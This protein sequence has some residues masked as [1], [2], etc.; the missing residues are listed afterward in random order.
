MF[1]FGDLIRLL[2]AIFFILPMVTVIRETGYYVVATL[3]GATEKK[4]IIGS[5]PT[6]LKLK[7][8]EIR[9]YFF[10]YSWVEYDEVRPESRFWT[11]L[12][13][14]S[15]ILSNMIVGLTV[16]F[17][18][19]Q[20]ILASNIFWQTFLFY[21]F[22]FVLFDMLPVYLPD[23]QPTNGRAI[24]DLLWHQQQSSYVKSYQDGESEEQEDADTQAQKE[25][26]ENRGRNRE[27]REEE[28]RAGG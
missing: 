2:L 13:Y 25:T 16:N 5:G 7:T 8:I 14:A 27:D 24:F 10:M 17:L 3:L 20:G 9:R 11:L 15:P 1:G 23:G 22:Y 6:V 21:V 19:G 4:L 18:V 12:L 26:M 28:K